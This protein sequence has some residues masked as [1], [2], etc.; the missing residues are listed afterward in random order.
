MKNNEILISAKFENREQSNFSEIFLLVLKDITLKSLIEAIYYGLEKNDK[1]LFGL[2]ENYIK[3][4]KQIPVLYNKKGDNSIIDITKDIEIEEEKTQD[5]GKIKKVK[6][7]ISVLDAEI[8]KLGFVTTI[9]LL[10]TFKNSIAD[11]KP[12]FSEETSSY[13]LKEKDTLEYNIS[14]RRL[15]VIEPSVIDIIAPPEMPK[16]DKTSWI[17]I[18]LPFVLTTGGMIGARTLIMKL[19]PNNSSMG[20]TMILMSAAMGVVS[21]VT[22]V[23]NFFKKKRDYSKNVAEW[24]KNYE[25]YIQRILK[26]IKEWQSNDI[27][28]LCN[29]YPGAEVLFDRIKN[30][31]GSIFSR[32]QNDNDFMKIALGISENI[33]PLF[34]IKG[35]KKDNIFYDVYYITDGKLESIDIIPLSIRKYLHIGNKLRNGL[36]NLTNKELLTDL[37]YNLA[38]KTAY[39]GENKESLP[40]GFKYLTG[41]KLPPLLLDLKDTGVLGVICGDNQT[42]LHFAENIVF[43]LTYYH[44][45]EDLQFVFFFDKE[46][47][48]SKQTE[49]IENFKFLPHTNELFE[50]IS[51]FVFN[52]ESS[53]KVFGQLLA[54]MNER[55]K[56]SDK[57]KEEEKSVSTA[58]TQIV[59]I[60]F[61]DY[62]IKESGFSKF[63]PE[64]PKEGEPYVNKFGLTFIFI[65]SV[66][67]KLP[68]YCGNIINIS[69]DIKKERKSSVRYNVL[70]RESL[71][72]L[73]T[74]SETSNN[75]A[76]GT[77][78]L[79]EYKEF[80]NEFIFDKYEEK[81]EDFRLAFK[82]LSSVYYTR[83]AENGKVPSMVTLF[84]LYNFTDKMVSEN[85]ITEYIKANWANTEKNDITRNL[86]IPMGK[87]EH[88]I[89]YLDLYEKADGPHGLV[90]G[91]TGSGKSETVITYLI[92]LCMK[93][94][95]MDLNL[96]LVDMKGGGF[97]DRLGCLPHCV[98]EVTDT[99]GESEGTS[100][101]YMLKR[102][103]ESLNAEIKKRKLLLSGLGVDN[104]DSY[105][106]AL[107]I[108]KKIRDLNK[109]LTE[110][111]SE[112]AKLVISKIE[113]HEKLYKDIQ[114]NREEIE[115]IEQEI[116]ELGE[117]GEIVDGEK[118]I[119][120]VD[121]ILKFRRQLN[122]KQIQAIF[123][124]E[125][126][127]PLSHLILVV[128]E[129]TELKRFSSE[130]ND[131]DFIAEITTI[132]RVGRTLGFHILLISQNIEGAITDDIRVNSKARICLKVATKQASKEMIDSPAAAAPT[133]P[134]N[135]RAYLLVGTGTRF[136]YF[137]S[138]YT[139]ANKNINILPA[140][141]VKQIPN[142][143]EYFD[144]YNSTKDNVMQKEKNKNSN[145]NDTQ[146]AY[147]VEKIT[148]LG[149]KKETEVPKRIF[150]EPLSSKIADETG[151][152]D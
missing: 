8:D 104:T 123:D 44:S 79:I 88:G 9:C 136:E 40:A 128:D 26:Q 5:D 143:G 111:D 122:P 24:K 21:L 89:V 6:D 106:R 149:N 125:K 50:G 124:E 134:L 33:K 141:T 48:F 32:S 76:G 13:I 95:P 94:S 55:V 61:Y 146:L 49:I 150:L 43:E 38:N 120:I 118:E 71:N 119:N 97:S 98:G 85:K 84:E 86:K 68:K 51:Q 36:K 15:N 52:K 2:F 37:P 131:V 137:Q 81:K 80:E 92:G 129:F 152:E 16:K 87:N 142:S 110:K 70:S 3:T 19:M 99:A 47:D 39:V 112:K 29:V 4:H 138:A 57:E 35:E 96:M 101:A 114:N 31:D 100:A 53:G 78:S 109:Q 54:I 132:A 27:N 34:E 105:I 63:L 83:I 30:I 103:L 72:I 75:K 20:N 102:F 46:D 65:Q 1:Q 45:P 135:G 139:G 7:K 107:R 115:K 147:I 12:L 60:V 77:D 117:I 17:D 133:M 10:F 130:S 116:K 82:R 148:E 144:F 74:E 18:L 22:S 145:E 67:D 151:W 41:E 28:Y 108:I 121:E 58:L 91:T 66:K 113:K 69:K 126:T 64:V 42:S 62:D 73:S 90:A 14:T 11:L 127:K 140:V 93:Y 59:C 23:Y 56:S 25:N